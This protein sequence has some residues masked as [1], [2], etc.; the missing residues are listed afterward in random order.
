LTWEIEAMKIPAATVRRAQQCG[1]TASL[2]D[3]IVRLLIRTALKLPDDLPPTA[4]AFEELAKKT[5]HA[6]RGCT[7][8]I[9]SVLDRTFEEFE[10]CSR[11]LEKRKS[12]HRADYFKPLL[13]ELDDTLNRYRRALTTD[14][15]PVDHVMRLPEFLDAFPLRGDAA[16]L[17]PA[18]YRSAMREVRESQ[19]LIDETA[20]V[21]DYLIE[22]QRG[23]LLA[24]V[25]QYCIDLFAGA[26]KRGRGAVTA[27]TV[28]Q[29]RTALRN[30]VQEYYR[31]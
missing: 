2:H 4:S 6:I 31:E 28:E 26:P 13:S 24:A 18:K 30:A 14:S 7:A 17:D 22:I 5:A 1:F 3:L 20:D 16:M 12:R 8:A 10:H 15:Y 23:R 11:Y 21:R 19:Q 27:I 25:E 29:E 9:I